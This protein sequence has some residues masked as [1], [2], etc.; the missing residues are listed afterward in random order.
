[1]AVHT[2]IEQLTDPAK[3][4]KEAVIKGIKRT[5][6]EAVGCFLGFAPEE[7]IYAAGLFPVGIWGEETELNQVYKYLPAFF[8]API[9]RTLEAAARGAYTGILKAMVMPVYCD[10]LRSAGQNLK[11]MAP[12]L[13]MIPIVYP[14]NRK[15]ESGIKFLAAEYGQA[16]KRLEELTGRE[17][18]ESSLED[19]FL[20]Y[21]HVRAAVR[22]FLREAK[23]HP[24]T[25]TPLIRHQIVKSSY[26]MDKKEYLCQIEELTNQLRQFPKEAWTGKRVILAGI[27][28]DSEELLKEME[29]QKIAVISDYLLQESLQFQIDTPEKEPGRTTLFRL[30]SR[31]ADVQ[32]CSVA[33]DPQ[34]LRIERLKR[35]AEEMGAEIIVCIPSFCDPEEFD[36]PLLKKALDEAGILHI[37][38]EFHTASSI[39]Q[40]ITKLQTFA[41]LREG[42]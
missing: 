17:I 1:M 31:F 42:D 27:L 30:A 21:N 14:A 25:I 12:D 26:Y 3:N 4:P 7:L 20:L 9:M 23:E 24:Q 8:C 11:I 22:S 36:Y 37:C 6:K 10:A 35:E 33:A 29:R 15:R 28:L 38:L 34:K 16:R 32:Y 2:L 13:P 40:A 41:E 39:G 19:A 5:G 18:T